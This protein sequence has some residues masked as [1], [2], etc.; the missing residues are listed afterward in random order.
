M[1]CPALSQAQFAR[2]MRVIRQISDKIEKERTSQPL[3]QTWP[4]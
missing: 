3:T 1:Q 4:T 2:F